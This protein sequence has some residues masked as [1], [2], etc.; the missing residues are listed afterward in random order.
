MKQPNELSLKKAKIRLYTQTFC[1]ETK[2]G[3]DKATSKKFARNYPNKAWWA[4]CKFDCDFKNKRYA[5]YLRSFE[6]TLASSGGT[7]WKK[8]KLHLVCMRMLFCS[9]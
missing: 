7:G 4:Y 3:K 1:Y 9:W 6:V 8:V 2:S 5:D